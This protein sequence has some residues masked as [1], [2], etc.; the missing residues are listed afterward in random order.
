[1]RWIKFFQYEWTKRRSSKTVWLS[2]LFVLVWGLL[3]FYF[4][5]LWTNPLERALNLA[6]LKTYYIEQSGTLAFILIGM[7]TLILSIDWL[8]ERKLYLEVMF[9]P[10]YIV[11]KL[12]LFWI[13]VM[14]L[15]V[16]YLTSIELI[17]GIS[18]GEF[19][20][21]EHLWIKCSL[22]ACVLSGFVVLWLR[23]KSFYGILFGLLF[24]VVF[25]NLHE[26]G[27][28]VEWIYGLFPYN[29]GSFSWHPIT[30]SLSYYW[31]GY[32]LSMRKPK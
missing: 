10:S 27:Q 25:P 3:L 2:I 9:G 22:N 5:H 7:H 13:E 28:T 12:A 17:Y 29:L 24:L 19:R 14:T 18:F 6:Y 11:F 20:I 4:S 1:M 15:V 30:V 16:F 32:H 31:I 21:H 26:L 23:I 8:S